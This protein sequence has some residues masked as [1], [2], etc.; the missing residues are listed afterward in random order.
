MLDSDVVIEVLRGRRAV[1]VALQALERSGMRTYCTPITVAEIHAGLRSGEMPFTEDFFRARGEVVL[2][3]AIA[4]RAGSY[5]AAFARS[6]G[7]ELADAFIAAA[8]T[9]SGL[10][11]WTLNRKHYPM[12]DVD[13]WAPPS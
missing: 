2:D 9:T 13:F 3:A 7:V 4:K 6:H 1:L 10:Q 5:L 11:L 8:A 12:R